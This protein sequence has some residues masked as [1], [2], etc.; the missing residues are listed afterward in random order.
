MISS[1]NVLLASEKRANVANIERMNA[2]D[3]TRRKRCE[4]KESES[5]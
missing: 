4:E 1:Q 5:G 2:T 3:G